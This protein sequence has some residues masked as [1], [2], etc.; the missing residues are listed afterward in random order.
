[1]ADRVVFTRP[2][3][4][5]SIV[6]PARRRT[7]EEDPTLIDVPTEELLMNSVPADATDV[8]VVDETTLLTDRTFRD[9][10]TQIA[11]NII[12]DMSKARAIH[13]IRLALAKTNE[14]AKLGLLE[15]ELR[16][17]GRT[18]EADQAV[19]DKIS[20]DGINL[21]T[22]ATQIAAAPN[23]VALSAIWPLKIPR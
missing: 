9:A 3:G 14:T 5:V 8:T 2:D 21:A 16:L 17:Q 12:V 15:A 20:V 23:P 13:A 1:M 19:I 6:I 10:W 22:L 7:S 18:T 4:G 11:G